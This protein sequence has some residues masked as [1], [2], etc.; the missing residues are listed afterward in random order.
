MSGIQVGWGKSWELLANAINDWYGGGIDGTQYKQVVQMLN[1]GNYT[2]E[3]MEGILQ[4]IPDFVASYNGEGKLV[5]VTYKAKTAGNTAAGAAANAVNSNVAGATQT[6]FQT[7]QN[8]TKDAQTG[9]VTM[10]DTVTKYNAG[11][12]SSAK[13][14]AGSAVAAVCAASTGIAVGK[15]VDTLLY[16][17]N[18]DFWDEHGMSTLNP[19]TWSSITDG[20]N[21]FGAKLFNFVFTLDDASDGNPT[22]YLDQNAFAYMVAYMTAQGVFDSA[23]IVSHSVAVGDRIACDTPVYADCLKTSGAV[24]IPYAGFD[25]IYYGVGGIGNQNQRETNCSFTV[26]SGQSPVYMLLYSDNVRT[27]AEGDWYIGQFVFASQSPFTVQYT[28]DTIAWGHE[29]SNLSNSYTKDGWYFAIPLNRSIPANN[30][31]VDTIVFSMGGQYDWY[32]T[33]S[34]DRI[35]AAYE[36]FQDISEGGG[37]VDGIISQEGVTQFDAS[38]ISD[39]S[40]IASVLQA[41]QTQFPDLWDNRIEV[42]PDGE[43]TITYIPVGFPTGGTGTQPTTNGATATDLAPDISGDGENSTNELIK[44]LID[45]IQN[46]QDQNGMESD[47]D[48]PTAPIDP[49]MPNGGSGIT[50][51]FVIPTGSASAL[52]SVYNPSQAQLNSLGAW[53]WSSNFV[54]QLLKLFND[55]MQAIIGLHKIFATPPTSGTGTIK[56]GYL[57]SGV[58]SNLVSAQYT[59]I[60]C[61]SV[62]MPEYFKNALDYLKTDIYLYLPFVG[63]VPLNVEDVTR[64]N[65]NVKYKVDVLTGACLASVYV[66][67]DA[68]GGG[69]L[70]VYAGNCAVQYPLSSGSYMGIVAGVLGIAGGV[71]SSVLSGGAL[72]PMAL[73]AGA[74]AMS[75]MKTKVEHS[76][77]LSG[78]SGAMGIKKPYLIIRRP[79]TKIANNFQLLA[80]ESQNEYGVLSSYTGQTRVK[81]VHLENIP[82]TDKELTQIEELLKSGVL[83]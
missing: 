35:N 53:L 22:A 31:L 39:P 74:S 17:A 6:Q 19:E 47:T 34:T 78:N 56:V 71:A 9:K 62:S 72:L 76:G 7:V 55:P 79:Q 60:D 83:I 49:N 54:D 24:T 15:M 30:A 10:S 68:N 61:G 1:S 70:Y 44:T 75:S 46:P 66:T 29:V 50:P 18:P 45:L 38:G 65:I 8:I 64:A 58:G 13:A 32:R 21:S 3:E 37:G 11:T 16:N 40:D 67:R 41:L 26:A 77:S 63:I 52:Y 73:G 57:D 2:M 28:R 48:T 27:S 12:A 25:G 82:A 14:I 69:Q 81:Y 36:Y 5:G 42:S 59:E 23:G 80:G 4:E 51:P 20:D 33:S 43:T